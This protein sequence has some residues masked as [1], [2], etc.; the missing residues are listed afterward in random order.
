M[1]LKIEVHSYGPKE[2]FKSMTLASKF[3]FPSRDYGLQATDNLCCLVIIPTDTQNLES[4]LSFGNTNLKR[5][6]SKE[7]KQ[8][9]VPV[10]W[11]DDTQVMGS[12]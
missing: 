10:F 12:K 2:K 6:G 3:S 11:N 9:T 4:S 5:S 8:N 7:V 1:G